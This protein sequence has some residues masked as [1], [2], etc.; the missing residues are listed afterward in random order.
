MISDLF[1]GTTSRL[2][3]SPRVLTKA[4]LLPSGE[5]TTF[6]R[7]GSRPNASREIA[8]AATAEDGS[9]MTTTANAAA[10]MTVPNAD[11]MR[12]IPFS[13]PGCFVF[14]SGLAYR[15]QLFNIAQACEL[16]Q[17]RRNVFVAQ[18]ATRRSG[19]TQPFDQQRK[20]RTVAVLYAC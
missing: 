6:S 4:I 5:M 12:I 11:T 8:S 15:Q 3:L 2:R 13:I 7:V 10:D 18:C 9:S 14:L 19:N 20:T 16:M 17:L 1:R